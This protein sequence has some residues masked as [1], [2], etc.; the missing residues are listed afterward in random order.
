MELGQPVSDHATLQATNV[1]GIRE[2]TVEFSPGVTLLVGRNATNRTSF[3]QAV[4]AVLGSRNASI[5]G[6]ADEAA[7]ELTLGDETYTRRLSREAGGVVTAGDPYLDDPDV[8]DLFAFLLESNEARRAVAVDADLRELIMR[9]VDTDE[10]QAEI[11]RLV[12]K[13][14]GLQSELDELDELKGKLPALE[15]ERKDLKSQIEA[16]KQD[17]EATEAELAAADADIDESR[18][19]TSA[20]DETLERLRSKRST[21]D[22]VRY[23]LE[24]EQ[25]SL[26]AT[27]RDQRELEARLADLPDV[28][29]GAVDERDAEIRRLRKEHQRVESE[30]NELQ[31][32]I[33]F[34][35]EMLDETGTGAFEGVAGANEGADA[36]DVTGRLLGDDAVTCWTCG[37]S[38]DEA[39][40]EATLAQLR[41][42][43]QET[44]SRANELEAEIE[45]VREEKAEYAEAKRERDRLEGRLETVA[46]EQEQAEERI[47]TLRE[48]RAQLT[49]EIESLQAD[50]DARERD[51]YGAVLEL[52]TE[53]NELEYE[54]GALETEFERVD[55][56]VRQIAS[57]IAEQDDIERQR[58]AVADEIASLR[59]KIERIEQ[60]AIDEFNEHMDSVLQILGYANLERI[61]IERVQRDVRDGRRTVTENAF[62]LHVVRT[63]ASG[64]AYEDTV[65]H[66]SESEREVTG[67]IFALA[68][69]LAH[70]VYETVPFVLLD[71][72]EAID[73]ERIAALV[74][75]LDDYAGYLLVALLPE[76]AAALDDGYERVTEI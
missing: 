43:S 50:V 13:R 75:Y 51:E 21:L 16:T 66:L 27:A 24:T 38:V 1:G 30:V 10:I 59:T 48:R 64:A 17:L 15:A 33:S 62:E 12:E 68:G 45:S 23:E 6:D 49:E 71:S 37:S 20:L 18:E 61:W 29:E 70:D 8:A 55:E 69:Y 73:S 57:R 46:R 42:R 54:L 3:L 36:D 40:I 53:A 25:E 67:L 60:T 32:V 76:D 52:H 31:S 58:E 2:T 11:D 56:N 22:D 72:L 34:N 47:A 74:D 44:V 26:E 65:D 28:P 19:E 35:E 39:Q 14:D 41:D 7:V 4:M 5:R 9:P 63:S